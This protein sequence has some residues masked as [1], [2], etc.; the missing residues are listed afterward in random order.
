MEAKYKKI[1]QS[2]KSKILEGLIIPHEKI[3]SESEL[4]EQF[5]VSRHTVRLALG[6]LVNENWLYR[7]QG[8]GTFCQDRS[9]IENNQQFE[10]PTKNIAIVTSY[11]SEYI[12]PTII[13]GAEAYLS[14][15]GY[16]VSIFN[17]NNQYIQEKK[18]LSNILSGNYDGVIIE[19]TNSASSNPNLNYYLKLE[20]EQIPYV[21][22][23]ATYEELEPTSFMIDDVEGGYMQTE[24]LLKLGHT[25]IACMYKTDD[26]QGQKRLKGYIKAHRD[27]KTSINPKNM[28][29]YCTENEHIKPFEAIKQLIETKNEKPTAMVCY[30]DQL[31]LKLMDVLREGKIKIPR[32]LSF[33]GYDDSMLAEIS[34][35]KLTSIIHPKSQ[36]GLDA[37]KAMI[38]M[39]EK[40]G[41]SFDNVALSKL[42]K[43][44][45]KQRQ[46]TTAINKDLII[47]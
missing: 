5:S 28:I 33:V 39:I 23:N 20:K 35:V 10:H 37:A 4:M 47:S 8:A 25:S 31:V 44:E 15:Q 3:S 11:I 7:E 46:S 27:Y 40:R 21:M 12:F 6:E 36:M 14:D 43:P 22:I 19:P 30:N 2:I 32:D 26:A 34:E 38:A 29:T 13:R 41:L 45:I 1:K 16:H 42:Y 9:K 18:I 24:H 17:T